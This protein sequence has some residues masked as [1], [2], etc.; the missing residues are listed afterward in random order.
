M[1]RK[2]GKF[3]KIEHQDKKISIIEKFQH[4]RSVFVEFLKTLIL[5]YPERSFFGLIFILAVV[6]IV[7]SY[8]RKPPVTVQEKEKP[9]KLVKLFSIGTAPKISTV[10]KVEKTGVV[11]VVAQSSG[12]VQKIYVKEGQQIQRNAWI[13]WISTNPQGGTTATTA[14]QIAQKNADFVESNYDTQKQ[15]IDSRRDLADKL[16]GQND[17]LRDI[18]GASISDTEDLIALNND[19]V[20]S[21]DAQLATLESTNINHSNDD[22][23]LQIKEGKAGV[24]SGLLSLNNALRNAQFQSD[25]SHEPARIS[26]I[27]KDLTM[28]QLD[29]EQKSLDLNYEIS[30]LNLTIAQ[31]S[32]SLMYPVAPIGGTVERVYVQPG[33][34]ISSGQIIATITGTKICGTVF[35]SVPKEIAS[36]ISRIEKS[37]LRIGGKSVDALP[38]YISKE[39]TE[40]QLNSVQF[41][42]PQELI[43]VVE[44]SGSVQVDLTLGSADSTAIIPQIPLDALY[45]TKT[46]SYVF[47]AEKSP[48]GG[49]IVKTKKITTGSVFGSYIDVTNGIATGDQIILDRNVIE[50]DKVQGI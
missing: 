46:E 9:A 12:I 16:D 32:E 40:G 4:S 41:I 7:G 17:K 37:T 29:I 5:K 22:L 47:V 15:M 23:I 26:D 30:I 27:T 48:D 38:S 43:D 10:G 2:N 24:Q 18:V 19:I 42:L 33:T 49:L 45:Q 25:A 31:I 14:R 13:A 11:K 1:A 36:K 3:I 20:S 39:P 44:N 8:M 28:K 50:G 34:N 21:L 6:I 35:V